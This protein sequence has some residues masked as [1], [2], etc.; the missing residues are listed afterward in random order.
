MQIGEVCLHTGDVVALANFYK[1]LFRTDNGSSDAVHQVILSEGTQLTVFCDGAE[2]RAN[3]QNI[4]LAFTVDDVDAEYR[5]LTE[6]GVEIIEKPARQPWGA[7][8]MSFL[9]PD[10]NKIYF[11]SF[12]G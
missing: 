6:M 5:R 4:S 8:N 1:Q 2:R 3:H 7:V 9:D 10:G 11:R 12:P